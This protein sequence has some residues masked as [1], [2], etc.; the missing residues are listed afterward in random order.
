[1]K[2]IMGI[3]EILQCLPHRYPFLLVDRVLEMT[4]G[5]R[6]SIVAL[7]NVTINET[8]FVGHFPNRPIMPGVLIL[9]A[10]AQAAAIL[11]YKSKN[12]QSSDGVLFYFA[13]IDKARF[14]RV[15]APGDQL[16][17]EAKVIR[18]RRDIWKL[19]GSAYVGNDVACTAE[20]LTS[21]KIE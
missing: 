10:I 2:C 9:E 4:V 15:I 14:R 17:L 20:L 21:G 1:M 5:E 11:A 13:G 8:F 7:K 16:R 19:K 3:N 6:G 18:Q 12:I